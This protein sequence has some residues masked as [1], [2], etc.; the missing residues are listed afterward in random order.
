[1]VGIFTAICSAVLLILK[2]AELRT[3]INLQ[4]ETSESTPN[5]LRIWGV[6]KEDSCRFKSCQ[7]T[8]DKQK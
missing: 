7:K 8:Q 2:Q 4:F 1:M 6:F 3:S 5:I